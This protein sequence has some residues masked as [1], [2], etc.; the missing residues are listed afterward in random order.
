MPDDPKEPAED[1]LEVQLKKLM[2]EAGARFPEPPSEAE[3]NARLGGGE[4]ASV[5]EDPVEA[6]MRE[7]EERAR[8]AK[9]GLPKAAERAGTATGDRGA[10]NGLATGF[11]V[12]YTIVG[13]P[14]AGLIVGA[15]LDAATGAN[16]WKAFLTILGAMVGVVM[17]VRLLNRMNA[18]Q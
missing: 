3:I 18:G 17:A 1:A 11:A 4:E 10:T 12:A 6:R 8:A 7:I 13:G 9:A 15:G 14:L 16:A 5:A 2:G